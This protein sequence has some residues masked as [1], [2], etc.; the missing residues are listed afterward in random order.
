M[1]PEAAA[2]VQLE[3]CAGVDLATALDRVHAAVRATGARVPFLPELIE[4]P[5]GRRRLYWP[6]PSVQPSDRP[7]NGHTG[8]PGP[9]Q[10]A[11]FGKGS[12]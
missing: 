8:T 10:P 4:S 1:T 7:F 2:E 6:K 12:G 9:E 11:L 3:A 5:S